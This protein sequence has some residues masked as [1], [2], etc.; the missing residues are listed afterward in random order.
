MA[1]RGV[2]DMTDFEL[3]SPALVC[4]WRLQHRHLPLENRHLRA[5]L[6]RDV[7]GARV[8]KELA[9][10]AKQHIEWTL[11][12][13][14]VEHPDGTLMLMVDDAGRAA[15]TVGPYEPLADTTLSALAVRAAHARKEAQRTR[16]APETLWVAHHNTLYWDSG[17][18]REMSGAASLVSQLALT[19]GIETVVSEGLLRDLADDQLDYDEA[20]LVSDEHGIV[21]ASDASGRHGEGMASAYARLLERA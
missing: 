6:A 21:P 10:W 3:G 15:M 18:Y 17:E 9:A 2:A 7:N 13:G 11:E 20:F 14:A 4:R 5:L 8:S 1:R 12:Q 16:V 19:L